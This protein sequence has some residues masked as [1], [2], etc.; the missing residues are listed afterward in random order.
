MFAVGPGQ[1]ALV[2]TLDGLLN[3]L[4]VNFRQCL[5]SIIYFQINHPFIAHYLL[6]Q[7]GL[8]LILY[9]EYPNRR[10][11]IAAAEARV[12]GSWALVR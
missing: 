7:I 1:I 5:L 11:K 4:S 2:T 12:V 3:F 9:E 8:C 10:S 6:F